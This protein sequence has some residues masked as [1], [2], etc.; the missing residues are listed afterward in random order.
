MFSIPMRKLAHH[1]EHVAKLD[2][3]HVIFE[4]HGVLND[5]QQ[6]SKLDSILSEIGKLKKSSNIMTVAVRS[7]SKFVPTTVVKRIVEVIG[8]VFV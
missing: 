3:S 8:H 5:S 1:L 7:F 2:F 6:Q 4:L